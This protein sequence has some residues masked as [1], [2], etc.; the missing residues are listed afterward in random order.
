MISDLEIKRHKTL[1]LEIV[2]NPFETIGLYFVT[3]CVT[4]ILSL[5]QVINLAF[6]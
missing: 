1:D 2:I 6:S 3:W 4:S 5:M